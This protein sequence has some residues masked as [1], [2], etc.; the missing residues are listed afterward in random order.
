MKN[1]CWTLFCVAALCSANAADEKPAA[2]RPE[3]SIVVAFQYPSIT[4]DPEDSISADLLVKNRGRRDE[5]VLLEVVEQPQDW[6][7]EIK[8]YGTVIGGIF[9]G[10]DEN[11]TLTVSARPKDKDLK[12]LPTGE[13]QIKVRGRTADGALQQ[14]T[15]LVVKVQSKATGPEEVRIETSYPV[16]EGASDEQFQFS[17]D[18][19]NDTGQDAVF[20]FRA[21]GPE[22][23]QTSFKPA[24][25]SK[26][27]SSL[28]I[29]SGSSKTV[30]FEVKPPYRAPAGEYVFKVTVEGPKVKAERELKVV[31]T[32]T[33]ELKVGTPSG[34]LSLVTERGQSAKTTLLV[35]NTGSAPQR[36]VTFTAFKPENWE[37]KFEPE[38]LEN[39]QP[40]KLEQVE[41]TITPS[42]KAVV[43]DYS[44][45]I[46]VD[47]EK[48]NEDLEFRVTVKAATAWGWV[49]VGIIVLV[50][51]G[52]GVTFRVLGRR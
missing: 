49:G 44:V 11:I 21:T 40:D 42:D 24:Y 5:T 18:I 16:L 38:K 12:R 6:N 2:D 35:Q 27:I 9:V 45:A 29:E 19:R 33:Y 13:F 34:L 31:L 41:V 3:R 51:V 8:R 25:E 47:G 48:A 50:V 20:N 28:K 46:N 4:L 17:L 1:L 30:E 15:S 23:W 36:Q 39:L 7:V 37:V 10:S 32:G 52:M 14:E 43:G 22:E 26:Q